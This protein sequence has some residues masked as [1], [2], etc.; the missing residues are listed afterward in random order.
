MF[1]SSP[2]GLDN[3]A[4]AMIQWLCHT[5]HGLYMYSRQRFSHR[6]FI[7]RM[8]TAHYSMY[9]HL[10]TIGALY[11]VA[12]TSLQAGSTTNSSWST[13]SAAWH[14]LSKIMERYPCMGM[15]FLTSP[16]LHTI[17]K[18]NVTLVMVVLVSTQPWYP[19]LLDSPT[20]QSTFWYCWWCI[21]T[22][23]GAHSMTGV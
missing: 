21:P 3:P 20:A 23:W 17:H 10:S 12:W 7:G 18:Q 8:E 11:T 6:T 16:P 19:L 13:T 2:S 15:L 14:C 4:R 22:C 9:S 5:Y 1:N